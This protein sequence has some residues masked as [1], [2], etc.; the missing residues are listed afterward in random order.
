MR[1]AARVD[2]RPAWMVDGMRASLLDGRETLEVVGE[3]HYQGNLWR[4]VGG[5]GDPSDHV[6]EEIIAVLVAEPGNPYDANAVGVWINGLKVGHL[7]R[8]TV[9]VYQPGLLALQEKQGTPIA[10]SCVIAGGGL[11]DDGPG[12]LGVFLDHDP[13][14]FGVSGTQLHRFA[15]LRA[16]S[17]PAEAMSTEYAEDSHRNWMADLP[18]DDIRAIPLLR[19]LLCDE[20]DPLARHF[21][22]DSL[23]A[24]LYRSRDVFASALDEY[25]QVCR[26]HDAE[27]DAIR[28][29]FI[30]EW[31]MCLT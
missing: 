26:E 25:D 24:R 13:A 30:S 9:R 28:R 3:S 17:G 23:E 14:D 19:K 16:L 2:E 21:I 15:E 18:A 4:L 6:R 29:V 12:R 11:R 5:R 7:A 8:E 27:M 1:G 31:D 22:Y 10:L 20:A